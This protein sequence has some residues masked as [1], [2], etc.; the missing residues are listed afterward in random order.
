MTAVS[1]VCYF[2]KK[3]TN[4]EG[5]YEGMETTTWQAAEE[6]TVQDSG[7]AELLVSLS[8]P[9][10][11][12]SLQTLIDSLPQLT[13]MAV[14]LTEACTVIRQIATDPV[15]VADL[16]GGFGEVVGPAKE[17]A[18]EIA[19]VVME[20]NDRAKEDTGTIGML[21]LMK[22]MKDP[23]AQKLFRFT[24]ALLETLNDKEKGRVQF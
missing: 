8:R 3:R 17:K 13:D 5:E 12:Q 7:L 9:E 14:K 15:F 23:Q 16:K 10:V 20:A 6:K 19:A 1:G 22:M 21:G 4:S 18:K 2:V 11:R 24:K